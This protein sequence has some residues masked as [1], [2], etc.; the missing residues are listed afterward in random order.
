MKNPQPGNSST[1]CPAKNQCLPCITADYKKRL[2]AEIDKASTTYETLPEFR[3]VLSTNS[4]VPD[5]AITRINRLPTTNQALEG[6]PDLL[7]EI[8][9][10]DQRSTKIITTIQTCLEEGTKLAWLID[11][12]EAIILVF[13]PYHPL[14]ISRGDSILPVPSDLPLT[15]ECQGNL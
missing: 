2:I 4:I 9:S 1:K 8:L 3:C 14:I 15:V 5:I 12:L 11:P 6:D 13:Q 7:I 10:P